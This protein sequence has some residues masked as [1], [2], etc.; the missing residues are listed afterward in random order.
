[1]AVI[2][3]GVFQA[4][5]TDLRGTV[6]ADQDGAARI[7][8]PFGK[9]DVHPALA[10]ALDF[11][12]K[13]FDADLGLV[14]MGVR[15]FDADLLQFT[16]P[17][18]LFL[19]APEAAL[20]HPIGANLYAYANNAPTVFTDSTGLYPD[21]PGALASPNAYSVMIS[22][23]AVGMPILQAIEA[24]PNICLREIEA[25]ARNGS[26]GNTST[27]PGTTFLGTVG[28]ALVK[29]NLD[30]QSRGAFATISSYVVLQP[31]ARALPEWAKEVAGLTMPD[32]LVTQ[33][34][35]KVRVLFAKLEQRVAWNNTIGPDT[36]GRVETVRFEP[37]TVV[38][39]WEVTTSWDW[40]HIIERGAKVGLWAAAMGKA[41]LGQVQGAAV[42]A[43]DRGA[44]FSLSPENQELLRS[45]VVGAGG[46]ISLI[47]DLRS[48][49]KD[50]V[51]AFTEMLR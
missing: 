34:G 37:G 27:H 28:E 47:K 3:N 26:L 51:K 5:A 38:S 35:G 16:S 11:V 14:R 45:T 8:S 23:E 19:A 46:Y 41:K 30:Y 1:V 49:A 20:A 18:P 24:S 10:A 31:G 15:D 33:V 13:G 25:A 43:I 17:D 7:A 21:R 50:D 29:R 32:L 12:E 40:Q 39:L 9:R 22:A 6:M 44:Y 4:V 2:R 48:T 42:L 36:R